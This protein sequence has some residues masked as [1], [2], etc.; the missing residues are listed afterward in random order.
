[1]PLKKKRKSR[2]G[3]SYVAKNV[4][5]LNTKNIAM[6][7]YCIVHKVR[8]SKLSHGF[9]YTRCAS[10]CVAI[11]MNVVLFFLRMYGTI[12]A[13]S[14]RW[15]TDLLKRYYGLVL[16]LNRIH[17]SLTNTDIFCTH[18]SFITN[19]FIHTNPKSVVLCSDVQCSACC[20]VFNAKFTTLSHTHTQIPG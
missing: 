18:S 7:Y 3:R 20:A 11:D 5:V 13:I 16:H 15:T 6:C 8:G 17:A 4:S 1:M 14:W 10:V 19:Q 2:L 12:A 9:M